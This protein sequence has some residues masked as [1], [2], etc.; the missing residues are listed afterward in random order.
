MARVLITRPADLAERT[1][2]RCRALGHEV[3]LAPVMAIKPRAAPPPSLDDV[4]AILVTSRN[5]VPAVA[6]LAAERPIYAVGDGTA[7]GLRD[8]GL[9]L[10][11]LGEGDGV[12]LARLLR[13]RLDPAAGA[14]LHPT[15]EVWARGLADALA[16]AGFVYRPWVVY[17]ADATAGLAD[18][19]RRALAAGRI[20]AVTL[21]SPRSA[22]LFAEQ[23]RAADLEEATRDVTALC[24]SANVAAAARALRWR[25]VEI[26]ARS[27]ETGMGGLLEDL[28]HRC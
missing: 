10:A 15:G 17:A 21:H 28:R 5:A 26:A 8:A 12:S 2:A 7:A 11:G 25:A 22:R 16:D 1:A 18:E 4:Q 6:R 19:A 23:L 20:D 24:L 13:G 3:V 14:L 27:D 9:A